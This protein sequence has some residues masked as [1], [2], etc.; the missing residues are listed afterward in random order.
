MAFEALLEKIH[1]STGIVF[2]K[3]RAIV[4]NKIT[5]FYEQKGF[6]NFESFFSTFEQEQTLYQE[7]LDLITT[8]ETYFNREYPQIEAACKLVASAH[9]KMKILSAPCASGEEA[10]SLLFRFL[11]ASI[12][13]EK[14]DIYALDINSQ[15]IQKAKEGL[16]TQRRI[17]RV[18]SEMLEKYFI[19]EDEHY[20]VKPHFRDSIHFENRNIFEGMPEQCSNFDI[21]FS[22][23]MLIYFDKEAQE[24][25]EIFFYEKLAV[26]GVL[27]LGHADKIPNSVGF[28]KIYID[29]AIAYVKKEKET[30]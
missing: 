3:N 1:E 6:E 10:Y 2:L 24:R 21:I 12:E 14:F 7:L 9:S 27:F 8:S 23:N 16:Y 4:E 17:Q 29:G 11:E 22:R 5:R 15:E 25:A 18:S 13:E 19:E 30:V 20:R 28:E 26:G